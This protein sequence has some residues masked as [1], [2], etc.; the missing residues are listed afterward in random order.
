VRPHIH[1]YL[2]V[3]PWPKAL[4]IT[5]YQSEGKGLFFF[6]CLHFFCLEF[7]E[8]EEKKRQPIF[9]QPVG[10][11]SVA[12]FLMTLRSFSG[13]LVARILSLWSNW[14]IDRFRLIEDSFF[15]LS[16]LNSIKRLKK[17]GNPLAPK[18]VWKFGE[19]V[20][21]DSLQ[22]ERSF[23]CEDK[24]AISQLYS[25]DCPLELTD[26]GVQTWI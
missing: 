17:G 6:S 25:R 12:G 21:G 14:T 18:S 16:L 8:R 7:K 3:V 5:L 22:S 10:K 20:F 1:W 19:F 23:S 13:P 9:R 15:L 11:W 2:L 4:C 26:T 24:L